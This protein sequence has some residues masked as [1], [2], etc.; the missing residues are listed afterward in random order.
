MAG[1]L[2]MGAV[3]L[4]LLIDFRSIADAISA[5]LPVLVG[6]ASTFGFMGMIGLDL[7]FA[8]LMVLPMIF[9]I[10]VDAGVHVIHRWRSDPRVR[11][12]GLWGGTGTG[13]LLTTTT[14]AIGFGSL[15]LAE[16]R[17]IQSLAIVM[18]I[19]LLATLV[20]AWTVLPAVLRLRQKRML[21]PSTDR[22]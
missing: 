9:G 15:M 6:F 19:G 5:I 12:P 8:N 21:S 18:V 14:T 2:A 16:H 20:A 4:I 17:G 10:G 22:H 1:L 11:P 13:I 7:N 3:L